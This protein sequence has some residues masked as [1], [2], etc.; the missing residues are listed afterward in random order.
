[1]PVATTM[2]RPRPCVSAVPANA[3]LRRS[4]VDS[5]SPS[6]ARY[7]LADGHRLARQRRLLGPQRHRLD[8]AGVGRDAVA[9]RSSD[10][11]AGDEG[12]RRHV[13]LAPV[14]DHRGG[15]RGHAP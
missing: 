6:T 7:L 15:G 2:P 4:P 1:M 8:E 9:G 10:E 5:D 13:L 14:P 3:M 12:G 11:V